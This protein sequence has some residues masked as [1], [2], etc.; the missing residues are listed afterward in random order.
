MKRITLWVLLMV[1]VAA[2]SSMAFADEAERQYKIKAGFIHKFLMFVQWPDSPFPNSDESYIIGVYGDN[3][4]RKLFKLIE[5][6]PVN[7]RKLI[8]KTFDG[9]E[10][11]VDELKNCHILFISNSLSAEIEEILESLKGVPVLTVSDVDGFCD[12]GGMINFVMVNNKLT[13]EINKRAAKAVGIKIRSKLL[14][15]AVRV[16]GEKE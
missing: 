2:C 6:R 1:T 3:P 12:W 14:R 5:D 4:F 8:I 11:G 10:T 9:E 13:F 16:I 15:V 7:G